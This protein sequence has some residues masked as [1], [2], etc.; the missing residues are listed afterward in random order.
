MSKEDKI[1]FVHSTDAA[2]RGFPG[3]NAMPC[4]M[5]HAA[6]DQEP[7]YSEE[8]KENVLGW[9]GDIIFT[10]LAKCFC[11]YAKKKKT[12][13]K[14]CCWQDEARYQNDSFKWAT[15]WH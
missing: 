9:H 2:G 12:H 8:N 11:K 4:C 7:H 15:F 3:R 14:C 13:Y 10:A 5:L 1:R 6:L